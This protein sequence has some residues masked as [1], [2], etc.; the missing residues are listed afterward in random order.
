[1]QRR[2]VRTIILVAVVAVVPLV[3]SADSIPQEPQ[4]SVAP[5]RSLGESVVARNHPRGAGQPP[6]HSGPSLGALDWSDGAGHGGDLFS[7]AEDA[8]STAGVWEPEL[9]PIGGEGGSA[10]TGGGFFASASDPSGGFSMSGA[11]PWSGGR[12]SERGSFARSEDA[13]GRVGYAAS[14]APFFPGAPTTLGGDG[15]APSCNRASS[16]DQGQGMGAIGDPGQGPS[17]WFPGSANLSSSPG[18]TP[19]SPP[20]RGSAG[21]PPISLPSN[22]V[23]PSGVAIPADLVIPS[24]LIIPT[25]VVVPDGRA[26]AKV[27]EPGS[28]A[29]FAT[30]L[31]GFG[32]IEYF[33]RRRTRRFGA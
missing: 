23:T 24:P 26:P 3:T 4:G 7:G 30:A 15:A 25:D 28:L 20:H 8:A 22:A 29:L 11:A 14:A 9:A 1:M 33:R 19:G 32:S 17:G 12:G 31:L 2:R 16:G 5:G 6:P 13:G 10:R 18:E 21:V 27:A